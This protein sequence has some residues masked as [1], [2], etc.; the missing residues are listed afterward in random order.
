M[1]VPPFLAPSIVTGPLRVGSLPLPV[2]PRFSCLIVVSS[3]SPLLPIARAATG[4]QS[5]QTDGGDGNHRFLEPHSSPP[6]PWLLH[7][8]R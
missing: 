3:P 2:L 5:Q 6:F 7:F 1:T 4:G 8:S